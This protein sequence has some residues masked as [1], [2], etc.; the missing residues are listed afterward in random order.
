[1]SKC[2]DLIGRRFGR[3]IVV[4]RLPNKVKGKSAWSMWRCKCDCG[5]HTDVL[6]TSLKNQKTRSCGC[7]HN[8][9]CSANGKKNRTHGLKST[10]LYGIWHGMRL[11]CYTTTN[12]DYE[13]YGGR[14]IKVCDEWQSF[15]PFYQ[16][17]MANGYQDALTLDRID[18]DGDYCPENCRWATQKEQQNNRRS[19]RL[20]THNGETHT[21]AEWNRIKGFGKWVIGNRLR[22]GWDI[23][24]AVDTPL[25]GK[26]CSN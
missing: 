7:L 13:R 19:N 3:L 20:I 25:G 24:S 10:R 14:G 4:E 15:E 5:N 11:R 18:N 6:G 16:W 1:M 2:V 23:G 9:S 26:R 12:K 22:D 8:E 17:A 21:I